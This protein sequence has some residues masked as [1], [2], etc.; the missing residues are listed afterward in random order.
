M[1]MSPREAAELD[2]A[3]KK[4]EWILD[5]ARTPRELLEF[6]A[7]SRQQLGWT[8]ADLVAKAL[9]VRIS[10]IADASSLR[11]ERHTVKLVY[12]TYA[13]A[14]LTLALLMVEVAHYFCKP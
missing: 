11:L 3:L 4:R 12:L 5:S 2:N 6:E 9:T 8:G 13:L 10:E 1:Q 7:I 14:A